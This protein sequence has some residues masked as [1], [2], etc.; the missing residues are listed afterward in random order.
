MFPRS[1]IAG[2]S[3]A[4]RI[5]FVFA[6][7]LA[8]T[9]GCTTLV[10]NVSPV[11]QKSVNYNILNLE[12][13]NPSVWVKL[14]ADSRLTS[15][16]ESAEASDV[17]YQSR[18]EDSIISLNSA[19]REIPASE[20]RLPGVA[21]ELTLGFREVRDVE[22]KWVPVNDRR[23]YRKTMT[24]NLEGRITRL[25]VAIVASGNCVYDFSYISTPENF[26]THEPDF[27]RFLRS[28]KFKK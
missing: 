10:G 19:C 25:R 7:V 18:D 23:A 27:E 15:K 4:A 12:T 16:T 14:P 21:Q 8:G 24:G 28:L 11:D 22:E 3:F 26:V 13:E 9:S 17:V 20:D 2:F 1:R 6:G 5:A